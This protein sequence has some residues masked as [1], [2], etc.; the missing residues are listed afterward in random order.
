MDEKTAEKCKTI[1]EEAFYPVA[2]I[3]LD[4]SWGND[5]FYV[6]DRP[7]SDKRAKMVPNYFKDINEAFEAAEA[8][9]L[10]DMYLLTKAW[11]DLD[12]K[13]MICYRNH[14]VLYYYTVGDTPAETI[15]EACFCLSVSND[16][17]DSSSK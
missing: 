9:K 15:A 7:D 6:E 2:K 5:Y 10:F 3:E 8:L 12:G 4:E 1:H 13:Y 14:G 16:T 17:F 11:P